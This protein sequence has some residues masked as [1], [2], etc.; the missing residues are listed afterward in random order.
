[1]TATGTA[2]IGYSAKFYLFGVF[3][4]W[5]FAERNGFS[6]FR[7]INYEIPLS[8]LDKAGH[9]AIPEHG[10]CT[11]IAR[12]ALGS[13][14]RENVPANNG[15]ACGLYLV[16]AP[17]TIPATGSPIAATSIHQMGRSK[18]RSHSLKARNSRAFHLRFVTDL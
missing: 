2:K 10:I 17:S 1:M 15:P 16:I 13:Q 6:A 3:R 18:R 12:H 8:R 7:A 4:G 9:S 14:S 5:R 11:P